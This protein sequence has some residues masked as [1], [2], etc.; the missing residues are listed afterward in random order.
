[1]PIEDDD[2]G[3]LTTKSNEGYDTTRGYGGDRAWRSISALGAQVITNDWHSIAFT[4]R[5]AL[6]RYRAFAD[7]RVCVCVWGKPRGVKLCGLKFNG[8]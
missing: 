5:M 3:H 7:E 4:I 8:Y 1:M 6:D 2:E